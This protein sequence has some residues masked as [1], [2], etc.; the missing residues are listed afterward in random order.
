MARPPKH[1]VRLTAADRRRLTRLTRA[2]T[3]PARAVTRARILLKADA[4]DGGPGW[5]DAAIAAALDCGRRTVARVR[6]EFAQAGLEAATR[7]KRP[8]G[9]R[10]RKLDGEQEAR[11]VAVAG[12][13]APAGRARWSLRL[14]A[15]RL[16]ELRVVDAV[17]SETVRRTLKKL[18]RQT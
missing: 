16:V 11:L 14:L 12:S 5:G 7:R 8:T 4:A 2:G 15:A 3:A 17:S 18:G 9:R 1:V 6:K 13:P 10:Y